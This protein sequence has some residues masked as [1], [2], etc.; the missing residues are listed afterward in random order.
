MATALREVQ[1]QFE[2]AMEEQPFAAFLNELGALSR[3]HGI[4]LSGGATLYVM[5]R[6]DYARSYVAG[7]ASELTFA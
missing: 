4:A 5:K 2:F 7:E 1:E 6:E 3:R